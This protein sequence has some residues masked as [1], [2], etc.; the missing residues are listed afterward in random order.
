MHEHIEQLIQRDRDLEGP[1][2]ELLTVDDED[3]GDE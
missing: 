3:E 1:E 2:Q